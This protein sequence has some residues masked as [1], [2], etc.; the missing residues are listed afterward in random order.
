MPYFLLFLLLGFISCAS[1]IPRE[2]KVKTALPVELIDLRN[3]FFTDAV[4]GDEV[5]VANYMAQHN[6][7]YALL[8]FGSIGCAKC[9]EKAL[10]LSEDYLTKHTLFL[11]K[12]ARRFDVIGVNTDSGSAQTRFRG[13][14]LDEGQRYA[15]GYNF[16]KWSDPRGEKMMQYLVAKGDRF[17]V[18]FTALI[19]RRGIL[20]RY[21]NKEPYSIDELVNRVLSSINGDETAGGGGPKQE[22]PPP[23]PNPGKFPLLSFE[24]PFRFDQV[25][26]KACGGASTSLQEKFKESDYL[27]VQ[28]SKDRCQADGVCAKNLDHLLAAK[29]VC[30]GKGRSCEVVT[31]SEQKPVSAVCSQ[32]DLAVFQGGRDFFDVFA[33]HFNWR[34]DPQFDNWGVPVSLPAVDG[35]LVFAFRRDGMLVHSWEGLLPA[36][37]E[38]KSIENVVAGPLNQRATGI[39]YP[40]FGDIGDRSPGSTDLAVLRAKAKYTV[41]TAFDRYCGG[42]LE[43]LQAWSEP[44][45]LNDYCAKSRGFCQVVA[46][47]AELAPT[48]LPDGRRSFYHEIKADF[49][50]ANH[51]SVPLLIDELQVGEGFSRIFEGYF[52]PM[53][54]QWGGV[55]GSVVYDREG[56]VM[57]QFKSQGAH[58]KDPI[59]ALLK[60]LKNLP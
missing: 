25:K 11:E 22:P 16:V 23:P 55:Y 51:I 17:G 58:A 38:A 40:V 31:L 24:T 30:A 52:T 60:T 8:M 4:T 6:L 28:V 14:M 29:A 21:S 7:D 12:E 44:A 5:N 19:N 34:Y 53:Y 32:A 26:A 27:V 35:P 50:A 47:E 36:A 48:N 15:H 18:P 3:V 45:E 39:N 9:N 42:C 59:L 54:P 33:T 1:E 13:I 2:K 57:A 20:W 49:F 37:D 10:T 56:K 41:V 46:L 43:E